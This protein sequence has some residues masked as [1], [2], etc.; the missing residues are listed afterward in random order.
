M[1]GEERARALADSG[2]D[3]VLIRECVATG[4]EDDLL[5]GGHTASVWSA[6]DERMSAQSSS[7]RAMGCAA[8]RDAASRSLLLAVASTSNLRSPYRS[9]LSHVAHLLDS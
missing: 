2:D 1:G 6:A 7:P 5:E 3:A 4:L 8:C 9:K